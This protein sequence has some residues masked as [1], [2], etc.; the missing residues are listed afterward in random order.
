M[1]ITSNRK[2][3]QHYA[4]RTDLISES[5]PSSVTHKSPPESI[6]MSCGF[7]PA[8]NV[9]NSSPA[10][11]NFISVPDRLFATHMFP[12]VSTAMPSGCVPVA[13]VPISAP[14]TDS[15]VTLAAPQLVT[16]TCPRSSIATS[17]G[18]V[19][20]ANA[21]TTVPGFSVIVTVAADEAAGDVT[22]VAVTETTLGS[23][24]AAG[25]V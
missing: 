17:S 11:E 25:A 16:Q 14:F 6:T 9:S 3:P 23:G 4:R 21:P 19:P 13:Y 22:D 24:N 18:F 1:R 10:D 12:A 15:S 2:R 8:T 7:I 20:T 5:A